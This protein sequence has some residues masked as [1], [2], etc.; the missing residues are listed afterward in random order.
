M[1]CDEAEYRFFT[2]TGLPAAE[3]QEAPTPKPPVLSSRWKSE[4][5]D[6]IFPG[7]GRS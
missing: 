5:P 2:V 1:T 7:F 6:F 4:Q 3:T